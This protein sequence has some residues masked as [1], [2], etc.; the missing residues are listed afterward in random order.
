[1]I[2]YKS[3][4]PTLL[5]QRNNLFWKKMDVSRHLTAVTTLTGLVTFQVSSFP[6]DFS[7]SHTAR[8]NAQRG[9]PKMFSWNWTGCP[10]W[11]RTSQGDVELQSWNMD[12]KGNRH[13]NFRKKSCAEK[14]W[15]K[16]RHKLERKERLKELTQKETP[17]RQ[18]CGGKKRFTTNSNLAEMKDK[19][20]LTKNEL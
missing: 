6:P 3:V 9:P 5:P 20:D 2:F 19:K 17:N 18:K 13:Q 15:H 1:M 14:S 4:L 10:C 11:N 16:Y 12:Q 8:Y 7:P